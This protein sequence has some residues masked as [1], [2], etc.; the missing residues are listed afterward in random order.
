[1]P[2]NNDFVFDAGTLAASLDWLTIVVVAV[3]SS[4]VAQAH[5]QSS[6]LLITLCQ[7]KLERERE[8]NIE[9]KLLRVFS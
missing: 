4:K 8:I 5:F 6:S 1:M 2:G 3:W 7:S 9:L